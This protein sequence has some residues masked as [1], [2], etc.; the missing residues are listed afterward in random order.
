MREEMER[1]RKEME[2]GKCAAEQKAQAEAAAAEH[3]EWVAG[4]IESGPRRIEEGGN[5][6]F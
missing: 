1:E 5:R 3:G 2:G 6:R 4:P